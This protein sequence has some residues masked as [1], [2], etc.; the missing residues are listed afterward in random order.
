MY[1]HDCR[2]K[3]IFVSLLKIK[4][5]VMFSLLKT[6]HI[7]CNNPLC[8][9][10]IL[11]L[12]SLGDYQDRLLWKPLFI[13]SCSSWFSLSSLLA[14]WSFLF[15]ISPDLASSSHPLFFSVHDP[16]TTLTDSLHDNSPSSLSTCTTTISPITTKWSGFSLSASGCRVTLGLAVFVLNRHLV[17][18][19]I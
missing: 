14:L 4:Y 19:V 10:G 12:L 7:I 13:G 3:S 9:C 16:T 5:A 15:F 6:Q 8:G 11:F 18:V 1:P 17:F 2:F